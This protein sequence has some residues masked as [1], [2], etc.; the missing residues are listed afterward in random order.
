MKLQTEAIVAK[1]REIGAKKVM[2]QVPDGLKPGVFD[3][4][5]ALSREFRIII[6]SDPF[7]G[8]CDVGDS[9]LYSDVDC[10]L[11]LGHSE[12]PNVRYPKPVVFIEYKEEKIPEIS[13]KIFEGLKDSGIMNIGLLFSIQYAEAASS[14]RT[15]LEGM[16]FHVIVGKNDGRLKYPGQVLGC[17]YSTGHSIENQVDCFLLVSTGIFHGLGAQLALR[18]DVYLLDLNDLTLRNL[19]PETD[20]VIRKR[21]AAIERAMNARKICVV[22]DTKIGQKREKLARVLVEQAKAADLEPVL[23]Y[24]NNANPTDYEN[25]RCDAVVFTGCPR[26][27]IDDQERYTMPIL[28]AT[29]FRAAIRAR[30]DSRY[31]MDEIVAVD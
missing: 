14:V 11:Q 13:E 24:S 27:P 31:I 23:I 19:S 15:M 9:S 10:I 7:F 18:K 20:R 21:Y 25:M 28:T 26:V 12:I 16:G 1:L 6:S 30:K 2:V 4:F 29:E 8:A 5:N 22:V 3:L 17:N